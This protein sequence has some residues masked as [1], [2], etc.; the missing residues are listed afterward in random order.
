MAIIQ[1]DTIIG[2]PADIVIDLLE[3]IN[4]GWVDDDEYLEMVNEL[5]DL[6]KNLWKKDPDKTLK[7]VYHTMGAW[8]IAP[9]DT[10]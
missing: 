8:Y 9:L 10:H 3:A 5:I 1:D 7:C 2:K 6:C 4:R